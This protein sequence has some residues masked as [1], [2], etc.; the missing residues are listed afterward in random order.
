M[1][2]KIGKLLCLC[3]L[4]AVIVCARPVLSAAAEETPRDCW[5]VL[6]YLCG[7]DLE[8][9]NGYVSSCLQEIAEC[10]NGTYQTNTEKLNDSIIDPV[11]EDRINVLIE[12]GGTACWHTDD[13]KKFPDLEGLKVSSDKLQRYIKK[14]D[15]IGISLLEELPLASMS[16]PE[17]LSSFIRWG[18]E[19]YPAQRY[20]LVLLGH[21]DGSRTGLFYDE[22]FNEDC[23]FLDELEEALQQGGVVFDVLTL[24][25]CMM[26]N[27]ETAVIVQPYAKY[28]V[29][30][31]EYTPALGPSFKDFLAELYR[32]PDIDGYRLARQICDT[33]QKKYAIELGNQQFANMLTYSVVDLSK[34]GPLAEAFDH[35]FSFLYDAYENEPGL[36]SGVF[37]SILQTDSYGLA[38]ERMWDIGSILRDVYL[39]TYIGSVLWQECVKALDDAVP[40][41]VRGDGRSASSGISFCYDPAMSADELNDFARNC[42]SA[43]M[44]ALLDVIH[45]EWTAPDWV[46]ETMPKWEEQEEAKPFQINYVIETKED[47]TPCLVVEDANVNGYWSIYECVYELYREYK[48]TGDLCLLGRDLADYSYTKHTDGRYTDQYSMDIDGY[49][50]GVEGELCTID[51]VKDRDDYILYNVPIRFGEKDYMMRVGWA[52]DSHDHEFTV[53]DDGSLN[54]TENWKG[55]YQVY[56]VWEGYD[57]DTSVPNHNILPM[58]Q[59]QGR[60]YRLLHPLYESQS[61]GKLRY[62]AGPELKMYRSLGIEDVPMPTGTYYGAFVLKDIFCRTHRTEL[63]KMEW[64]GNKMTV[65]E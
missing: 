4:A 43:P 12:T 47:G 17:T 20:A 23:M 51:M 15:D 30:S 14:K 62:Q 56:G 57:S 21:G 28:M 3:L 1:K 59:F 50:P 42:R 38:D 64:D 24:H 32:D 2:N 29:S 63:I 44:L 33:I 25:A 6:V 8:T 27:L 65:Q 34:I 58:S 35:L 48:E 60:T 52:Y 39:D 26:A 31:E 36:F 22:L 7:A 9:E 10:M 11:L 13:P 5:T 54:Y 16:E 61:K 41:L 55:E 18:T 45:P 19:N 37:R 46:Y 40:Y 53:Q 49:W